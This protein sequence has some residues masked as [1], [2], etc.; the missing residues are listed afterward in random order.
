[1]KKPLYAMVVVAGLVL[2]SLPVASA[3]TQSKNKN[4]G[5]GQAAR[6]A[7]NSSPTAPKAGASGTPANANSW[8]WGNRAPSTRP[9]TSQTRTGGP[10]S[11]NATAGTA[12]NQAH[13]NFGGDTRAMNKTDKPGSKNSSGNTTGHNSLDPINNRA[14]NKTDKPGSQNSSGNRAMMKSTRSGN[15]TGTAGAGK[16]V[17]PAKVPARNAAGTTQQQPR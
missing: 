6:P 4:Q 2:G 7:V 1:M 15:V 5:T 12:G 8:D 11:R 10:T 16:T 9:A 13:S 3:Q 17:P 14:M